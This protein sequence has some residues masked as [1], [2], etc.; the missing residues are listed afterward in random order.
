MRAKTNPAWP[1]IPDT[2][3]LDTI[4]AKA[5]KQVRWR[6]GEDGYIEVVSPTATRA[7]GWRCGMRSGMWR[8]VKGCSRAP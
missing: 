6:M 1:W 7:S 5:L 3:G 2:G 4:K 8:S